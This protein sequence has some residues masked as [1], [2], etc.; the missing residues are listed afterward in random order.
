MLDKDLDFYTRHGPLPHMRVSAFVRQ[1][2]RPRLLQGDWRHSMTLQGW[3]PMEVT[4]AV[5]V[6]DS[7]LSNLHVH[8]SDVERLSPFV[9][10]SFDLVVANIVIGPPPPHLG[11]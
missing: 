3:T 5:T 9:K 4:E 7:A 11:R 1:V 8:T 10:G 6:H 2:A